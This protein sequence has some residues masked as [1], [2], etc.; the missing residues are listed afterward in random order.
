MYEC[1][2]CQSDHYQIGKRLFDG[3]RKKADLMLVFVCVLQLFCGTIYSS[4]TFFFTRSYE[5][6]AILA[7]IAIPSVLMC[8]V[9]YLQEKT[10][11]MSGSYCLSQR[12][13]R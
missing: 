2:D 11:G 12:S 7:N 3:N 13:V 10:A 8:A 9:W 6:K 1:S 4:G 5:G